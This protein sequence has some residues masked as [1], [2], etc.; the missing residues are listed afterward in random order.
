LSTIERFMPLQ[1]AANM[2]YLSTAAAL[3]SL[4]AAMTILFTLTTKT[5]VPQ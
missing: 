1:I 5:T 3:V 2:Q 4:G